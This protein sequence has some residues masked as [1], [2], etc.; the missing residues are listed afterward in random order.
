MFGG[1]S[2]GPIRV[3]GTDLGPGITAEVRLSRAVGPWP[4]RQRQEWDRGKQRGDSVIRQI[5]GSRV[6]AE[7]VASRR[8]DLVSG[9][10]LGL[11]TTLVE[12]ELHRSHPDRGMVPSARRRAPDPRLSLAGI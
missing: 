1:Q 11:N 3:P 6:V 10:F 9:S 8:P 4:P 12:R 2:T 7:A 5:E